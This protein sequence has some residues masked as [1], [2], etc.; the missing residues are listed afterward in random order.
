MILAGIS[1]FIISGGFADR[2]SD[3]LLRSLFLLP[4]VYLNLRKSVEIV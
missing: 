4:K 3:W 2:K 1:E